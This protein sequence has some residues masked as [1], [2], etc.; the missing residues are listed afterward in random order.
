MLRVDLPRLDPE[1]LELD[2]GGLKDLF[3]IEE[4]FHQSAEW[5]FLD[6]IR[7]KIRRII[8][9]DIHGR[10]PD[11]EI[12][13]DRFDIHGVDEA[14]LHIALLHWLRGKGCGGTGP[15]TSAQAQSQK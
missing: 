9:T 12:G 7:V 1:K 15:G 3:R 6:R 13:I 11:F 8:Q 5:Q 4:F 14:P 2:P 10:F